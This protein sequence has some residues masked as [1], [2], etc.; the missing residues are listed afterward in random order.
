MY[1]KLKDVEN[2]VIKNGGKIESKR[3]TVWN[4]RGNKV[5]CYAF[6]LSNINLDQIKKA[7][8]YY[9][10]IECYQSWSCD[11][12]PHDQLLWTNKDYSYLLK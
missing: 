6:Q 11:Y 10:N 5:K 8:Y 3:K 7:C 9:D 4:I 12:L 1:I 2:F